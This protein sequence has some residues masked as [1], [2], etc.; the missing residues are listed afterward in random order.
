[1]IEF[2][3]PMIPPTATSQTKRLVMVGGKPRFFPKKEHAKAEADLMTLIKP[4]APTE[5]LDGPILLQV[6][7][8]FPWRKTEGKRRKEWGRIPNDKRP[9]ADNLV[10]LVG[11]VLTKA[12]FYADDGQVADLRVAKYWG[13]EPGIKISISPIP[14]P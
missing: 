1:M 13:D 8:T 7:F 3:L 5:P 4:K 6:D 10:K 14:T 2:F 12:N 9:D 11:D